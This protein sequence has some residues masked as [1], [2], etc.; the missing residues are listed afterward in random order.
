ML[1][2]QPTTLGPFKYYEYKQ[3]GAELFLTANISFSV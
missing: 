3:H 1:P 2:I